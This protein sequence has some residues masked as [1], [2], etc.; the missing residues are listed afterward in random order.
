MIAAET[1]DA[2]CDQGRV[3]GQCY[4]YQVVSVPLIVFLGAVQALRLVQDGEDQGVDRMQAG[5]QREEEKVPMVALT[6]AGA[7]PGTMMVVHLN[8]RL[9]VAAVERARRS[10]YVASIARAYRQLYSIDQADKFF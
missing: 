8:A 6:D 9:A 2:T 4:G 3:N 1:T 7:D 5:H 10:R